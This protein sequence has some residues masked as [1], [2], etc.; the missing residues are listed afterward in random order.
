VNVENVDQ[1]TTNVK[2]NTKTCRAK[3]KLLQVLVYK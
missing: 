2:R 3:K 1:L